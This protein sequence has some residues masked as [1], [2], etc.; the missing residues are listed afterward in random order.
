MEVSMKRAPVL[1]VAVAVVAVA[2]GDDPTS[3]DPFVPPAGT[4]QSLLAAVIGPGVGG[5][6][7]TPV[8]N[9]TGTFEAAIKVRVEGARPNTTYLVQR[10]PEI[11]RAN[12]SD[13]ICQ[14]ALGQAPWSP[15]DPPAPAFVTFPS[16]TTPGALVGLTTQ[17]NGNGSLDFQFAAPTIAAGTVFDV[18]FR[19]VDDATAPTV[20][21]RSGCFTVT[22]R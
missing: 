8:A 2:C 19:L 6:S 15:S 5:V 12:G 18:M 14:R 9:A 4:H 17:A 11:G 10:A 21:L 1:A 7:V 16:P 13:G 20:E 3:P 22:A